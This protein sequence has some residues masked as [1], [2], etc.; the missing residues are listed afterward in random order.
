[1]AAAVFGND[2]RRVCSTLNVWEISFYE[3]VGF[4]RTFRV[5]MV[6]MTSCKGTIR[7]PPLDW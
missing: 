2:R 6:S 4:V 7:P 3:M 1:M 5:N